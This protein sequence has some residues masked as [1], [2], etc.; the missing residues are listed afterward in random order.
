MKTSG[1]LSEDRLLWSPRELAPIHSACV[2]G[3]G[4]QAGVYQAF[5]S[6][7]FCPEARR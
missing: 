6:Y 1:L 5:D 4:E 7:S 2:P 3:L